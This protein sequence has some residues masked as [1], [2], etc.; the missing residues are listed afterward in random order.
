MK[1]FLYIVLFF[2]LAKK[3]IK[4]R[5]NKLLKIKKKKNSNASNMRGCGIQAV[6]AMNYNNAR[7]GLFFSIS[8]F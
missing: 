8:M 1:L 6:Q 2:F 7:L 5:N 3:E 4:S